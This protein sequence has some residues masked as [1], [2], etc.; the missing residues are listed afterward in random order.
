MKIAKTFL[1]VLVLL[2]MVGCEYPPVIEYTS[3]DN[4]DE[5][6]AVESNEV[7]DEI[8]FDINRATDEVFVDGKLVWRLAFAANVDLNEYDSY[9][10]FIDGRVDEELANWVYSEGRRYVFVPYATL[11]DFQWVSV[12]QGMT[13][14]VTGLWY[15]Q[16]NVLYSAGN[17]PSGTPFVVTTLNGSTP[18]QGI[19]FL[20]ENGERRGFAISISMASYPEGFGGTFVIVELEF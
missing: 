4:P 11:Y 19:S 1:A 6:Y 5:L 15:Y 16:Q 10:E 7:N 3:T 8:V 2:F 20:D 13:E 12:G 18:H 14:G 9:I 17:L